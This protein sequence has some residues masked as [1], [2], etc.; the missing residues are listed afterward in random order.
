MIE[1]DMT[2]Q[3]GTASS[4]RALIEGFGIKG[5]YGYRNI[6][7]ESEYAA[8]ILIA[9]NGAGKTT[10]LGAL[11]AVLKQQFS[12]LRDVVFEELWLKVR[13]VPEP[14]RMTR[15]DLE[16]L[17]EVPQDTE[18][19]RLSRNAD[20][21]L[22]QLFRFFTEE[23]APNASGRYYESGTFQSINRYLDYN[24]NRA[25]E[26]CNSIYDSLVRRTEVSH[27]WSSTL[28][29]SLSGFEIVYLPTYRRVELALA[30]D[31]ATDK[32]GRKRKS[33]IDLPKKGLFTGDIQF[34]LQDILDRL[35]E[36]NSLI[37]TESNSGYRQLSANVINE[38]IEGS[39]ER[40]DTTNLPI[41]SGEELQLFLSR[42]EQGRRTGP[43]YPISIPNINKIY[44]DERLNT[45]SG[46][47]LTYF[48]N[49]LWTVIN[50][51]QDVENRVR[52]FIDSCNK[53]LSDCSDIISP[54]GRPESPAQPGVDG[55]KLRLNRQNLT[56]DVET[57]PEGRSIS[58]DALSSGEKQMISLFAKLFLYEKNKI[59]LI[60]EPELSLSIDWQRSILVDVIT[61]P[62]CE[63]VIAITHSPFVFDNELEPFARSLTV[64]KQEDLRLHDPDFVGL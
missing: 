63:Q 62:L 44:T 41:P 52:D 23:W 40:G 2:D 5:L 20:V 19:L 14:L 37:V 8:T 34:G 9:R 16:Q 22:V 25:V 11:D 59:V 46:K 30:S 49:Q 26:L 1:S 7:L 27:T 32:Y 15:G 57:I 42:L 3:A 31:A 47:Y 38:L 36:L 64:S 39:I 13:D 45:E 43:Y 35:S 18:L 50:S 4:R 33:P 54:D 10:L 6:S 51:T 61:A 29:S 12:R 28:S 24:H 58:L 21:S 60:D 55:K 53:Y 17:L 48:L 56:V